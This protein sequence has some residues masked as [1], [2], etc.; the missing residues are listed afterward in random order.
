V[1]ALPSEGGN[2]RALLARP[3]VRILYRDD[4]IAV[5]ERRLAL[6]RRED[7]PNRQGKT[8]RAIVPEAKVRE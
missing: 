2:E 7:Y 5:L 1:L 3:G 4:R 6:A 8:A